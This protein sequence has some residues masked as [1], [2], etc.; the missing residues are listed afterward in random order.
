MTI[1]E[2]KKYIVTLGIFVY[3]P[4]GIIFTCKQRWYVY[5]SIFNKDLILSN[6]LRS[7]FEK[8]PK[9]NFDGNL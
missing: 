4:K 6:I 7:S 2:F 3:F 5:S 9:T 8:L 1:F